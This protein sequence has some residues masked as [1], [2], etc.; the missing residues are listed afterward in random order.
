MTTEVK[1]SP[2]PVSAN[3]RNMIIGVV[4]TVLVSGTVYLLGFNNKND[5]ITKLQKKKATIEARA[6][7]ALKPFVIITPHHI[8]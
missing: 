1:K 6:R 7:R 2:N 3:A 8:L 5:K 4:T